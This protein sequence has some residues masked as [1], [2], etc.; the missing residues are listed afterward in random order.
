METT[1]ESYWKKPAAAARA[2]GYVKGNSWE[3]MLREH[4][5]TNRQNLMKEL[6]ESQELEDYV[7]VKTYRAL[8]SYQRLISQGTPPD[9]AEEL[10]REELFPEPL[11]EM[12]D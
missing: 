4:L 9:M 5:R 3:K 10:A 6:M 7:T 1:E 12:D 2:D 8:Q 11:P